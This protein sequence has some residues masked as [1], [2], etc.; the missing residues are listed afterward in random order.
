MGERGEGRH[1]SIRIR[2]APAS[3]H[4]L[5]RKGRMK[6]RVCLH[7]QHHQA[8]EQHGPPWSPSFTAGGCPQAPTST[9]R[10]GLP[11]QW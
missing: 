7:F 4:F 1:R 6:K 5:T 2:G 8:G 11:L 3:P 9:L 10:Q